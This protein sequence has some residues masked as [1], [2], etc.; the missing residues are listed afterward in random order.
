MARTH[1]GEGSA[2]TAHPSCPSGSEVGIVHVG[3]GSGAPYFV[4]G[5]AY[6]AGPYKGAPFSLV[7]VTPAVAGPFDLGTV[8]VRAGLYIDPN[9][10]QVSVKSDPFPTIIDGIPLDIRDVSVDMSRKE[11]T[12]NPTS[13]EPMSVTG[14]ESSTAGQT[15]SLSDRFQA[16]GCTTLPFHPVFEASTSGVTSRQEGASLTVHVGSSAGQAN[17]AK[18]HVKLPKQLP[19]RLETLKGACPESVFAANPA[20]C[21]AGSAVGT[22]VAHTPILASPLSGPA[23]IVSH[24]GAAFPDLEVVLQAEGVTIILDGKTNIQNGITE[25]SFETVPD[26]PVSSF[27]LSLPEGAHSILSAPGGE[28]CSLAT[29]TVLVKKKVLVNVKRHGHVVK[30]HERVVKRRV[31]RTVKKTVAA[32]LLMPTTIQ[33]QNGAVITQNTTINVTGCA[34]SLVKPT[35]GHVKQHKK[36]KVDKKHASGKKHA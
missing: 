26:A 8:V 20:A 34:A 15:A 32:G 4:T 19:S 29:G 28:L 2:E 10:A 36:K 7:I 33:G 3:A 9:T 22:A 31:I 12:L 18:V 27:E 21:P 17:I 13:C 23:Y 35:T 6:F 14:A 30:R 25:S 24:G 16:G 5:H 11:F 1:E